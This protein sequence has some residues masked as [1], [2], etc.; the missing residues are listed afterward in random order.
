[1]IITMAKKLYRKIILREISG[2][3]RPITKKEKQLI[4]ELLTNFQDVSIIDATNL[5]GASLAW[6]N[7]MNRLR[8][9]IFNDD[10]RK[11]LQWDVIR[12]TMF[13]GNAPYVLTELKSLKKAN[14]FDKYWQKGIIESEIGL[15]TR[16]NRYKDSSGNLIHHAYHLQ[17]LVEEIN[18]S[19]NMIDFV[20]EFGGGYGSMCRLFKNL[21]FNKKYVIFDLLPFSLL[22]KYYLKSLGH[23]LLTVNEFYRDMPGVLCISDI[24]ELKNVL[25]TVNPLNRNLFISTWSIS[26]TPMDLRNN[27]FQLL[28]KFNLFLLAYQDRFKEVDNIDYFAN[29]QK[30][31]TDIRWANRKI[32]HAHGNNYLIGIK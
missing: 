16:Y 19:I 12:E 24:E 1:M 31:T 26:E 20:F 4:D 9:L 17:Q 10:P 21:G 8:E 27:I 13:V 15:P 23:K 29:M 32:E 2:K 5:S 11:F 28:D 7:N 18:V 6:A 30:T 22:Q 3:I 14:I 25:K